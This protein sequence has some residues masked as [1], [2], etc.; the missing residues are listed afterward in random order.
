MITVYAA[1]NGTN[2]ID[3]NT[4]VK[5]NLTMTCCF[6]RN[7]IDKTI[8]PAATTASVCTKRIIAES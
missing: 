7:P 3:E 5:N 1:S 8:A 4:I 2:R 6:F